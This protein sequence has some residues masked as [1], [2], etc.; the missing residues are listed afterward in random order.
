[1]INPKNKLQITV[2]AASKIVFKTKQKKI[3]KKKTSFGD[4]VVFRGIKCG[5]PA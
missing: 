3:F 5:V 4:L 1:M 2:V